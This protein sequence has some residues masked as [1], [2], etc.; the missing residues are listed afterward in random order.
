MALLVV[1]V[2]VHPDFQPSQPEIRQPRAADEIPLEGLVPPFNH[3]VA[4][5]V[6]DDGL[7]CGL[8]HQAS[9]GEELLLPGIEDFG[10]D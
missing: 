5:R 8:E 1:E 4:L 7:A 2:D 3:A 9:I 10:V 6:V